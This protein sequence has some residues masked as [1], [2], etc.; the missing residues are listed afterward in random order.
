MRV[1]R[2]TRV[3]ACVVAV[4]FAP[5]T[6]SRGTGA[7]VSPYRTEANVPYRDGQ[8]S[9]DAHE[10]CLLDL[11]HPTD[12]Q[13]FPTLVWFHGGGLSSGTKEIPE[14]LKDRG[15]AVV[16]ATYRLHPRATSPEYIEDAAAAV[17]WTFRNIER[18]GGSRKR[19]HV[20]GV[21][22]G[23][24]LAAM[25][26][27]DKRWLA[28]HGID[29]NEIAGTIPL[30]GQMITHFTIRKERG[31]GGLT[32]VVDDLAPLHHVRADASP[33]LLITGDRELEIMGRYE[34]NAYLARMM[35]QAGHSTTT[36]FELE[37]FNHGE[38]S[39]PAFPLVARFIRGE[40]PEPSTP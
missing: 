1:T 14:A 35:R 28:A 13:G 5:P 22:A 26:G 2:R 21:S 4:M 39:Q 38:M 9:D 6:V 34:E 36:L 31:V 33:L 37:G 29:A 7:E 27:L 25:I 40:R 3:A 11:Y 15:F 20:G 8:L 12:T 19:I 23:G 24:Y 17:A 10:R 16:G 30:S 18:H 32:P